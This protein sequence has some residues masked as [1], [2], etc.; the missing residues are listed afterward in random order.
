MTGK[1]PEHDPQE[2]KAFGLKGKQLVGIVC[3]TPDGVTS[4][5]RFDRKY[6]H[7]LALDLLN[8]SEIVEEPS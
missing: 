7:Q 2:P 3:T 4:S 8:M 1:G 6:V 5:V